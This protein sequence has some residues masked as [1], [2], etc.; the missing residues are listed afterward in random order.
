MGKNRCRKERAT[1][2]W[3]L[4]PKTVQQII[5]NPMLIQISSLLVLWGL[6]L[7]LLLNAQNQ[8]MTE[9]YP[10]LQNEIEVKRG[11]MSAENR[12]S[13]RRDVETQ[14]STES[15]FVAVLS[16]TIEMFS[17][18]QD[19]FFYPRKSQSDKWKLEWKM[20]SRW[21][22]STH[23]ISN[24]GPTAKL[25][26]TPFLSFRP[27]SLIDRLSPLCLSWIRRVNWVCL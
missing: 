18:I 10:C 27:F 3:P 8:N 7:I 17:R 16:K 13:L 25:F 26:A 21:S 9:L 20:N 19:L 15:P 12:R 5:E 6:V 4:K 22:Q 2:L 24:A 23:K 14:F 11:F 1:N